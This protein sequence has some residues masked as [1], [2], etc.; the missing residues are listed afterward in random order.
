M[1]EKYDAEIIGISSQDVQSKKA[2]ACDLDLQYPI[3]ADVKDEARK[4]FQVPRSGLGLLP[5]RVTY[6]LDETGKCIH[7]YE[8]LLDA[9]SH[10]DKAMTALE[11]L[12]SSRHSSE[13]SFVVESRSC[14]H[15]S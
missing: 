10:V 7:M 8:N 1:R 11:S 15:H 3:L 13:D 4:A 12:K 9:V 5:G 6:V 2:F 14:C